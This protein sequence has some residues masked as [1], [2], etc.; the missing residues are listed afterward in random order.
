MS[1]IGMQIISFNRP[2][3]LDETLS[4]LSKVTNKDDKIMV[5][6][7]S[8][9][10]DIQNHCIKICQKYTVQVLPLFKNFGQRKDANMVFETGFFDD[11]QYVMI[12]DHD[13]YFYEDLTSYCKK[14]DEEEDIWVVT[15]YC[16]MEHD[17]E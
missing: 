7:Q 15:G 8:D 6:E 10:P 17:I 3:Y 2:N 16:S 1:R 11:C 14:L 5:V 13:N 4:S 9:N 12:S